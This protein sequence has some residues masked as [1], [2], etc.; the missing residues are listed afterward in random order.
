MSAGYSAGASRVQRAL[1]RVADPDS[2]CN[3][4]DRIDAFTPKE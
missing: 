3:R 1:A 2:S 4:L